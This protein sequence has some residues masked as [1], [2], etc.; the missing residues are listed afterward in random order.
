MKMSATYLT[1]PSWVITQN[2]ES[3]NIL[4]DWLQPLDRQ[5]MLQKPN[6][7]WVSNQVIAGKDFM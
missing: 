1:R 3:A 5:F 7:E 6:E 2:M 4:K